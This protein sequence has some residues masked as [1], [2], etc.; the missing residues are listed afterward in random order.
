MARRYII[1]V[2]QMADAPVVPKRESAS[3]RRM[4]RLE[5]A[6][7][8]SG[9]E[10]DENGRPNISRSALLNYLTNTC[11]LSESS[12]RQELVPSSGRLIG[13]LLDNQVIEPTEHG[14]SVINSVVASAWIL[15]KKA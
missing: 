15:S 1:T 12:A 4:K 13:N 2:L 14:W 8:D 9:A 5:A 10:L 11:E 6:W 3:D 7:V